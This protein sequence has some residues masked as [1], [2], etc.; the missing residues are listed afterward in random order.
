M[1]PIVAVTIGAFMLLLLQGCTVIGNPYK[2]A[3]AMRQNL[4]KLTPIGSTIFDVEAKLRKKHFDIKLNVNH[5]FIRRTDRKPIGEM[6]IEAHLVSYRS[7]FLSSTT[8]TG[9]WGF[10]GESRLVDVWVWKDVDS[11]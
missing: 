7:G 9:F 10:D 1:K 5:G 3:G 11:L 6:S 8:V 2:D 4:L